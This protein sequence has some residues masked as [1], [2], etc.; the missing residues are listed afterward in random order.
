MSQEFFAL[1]EQFV[2]EFGQASTVQGELVRSV[3]K[4]SNDLVSNG[5]ANWDPD[6]ERLCAFALRKLTDGTFGPATSTGVRTDI[7]QLQNYGRGEDTGDFD[8]EAA[9]DRL[10]QAVVAWCEAHPDPIPHSPDPE[11]MR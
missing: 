8:L 11:L 7:E 10:M 3:M 4:L 6:Y 1:F 5:L 2:P 9:C